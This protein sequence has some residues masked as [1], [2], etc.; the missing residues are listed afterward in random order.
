MPRID[1]RS[2]WW[3]KWVAAA[4]LLLWVLLRWADPDVADS[5]GFFLIFMPLWLLFMLRDEW[6]ILTGGVLVI[7]RGQSVQRVPLAAA[8]IKANGSVWQ[9]R[10]KEGRVTRKLTFQPTLAFGEAVVKAAEEG[11]AADQATVP[12]TEREAARAVLLVP[13]GVSPGQILLLVTA[14]FATFGLATWLDQPL[15]LLVWPVLVLVSD[16]LGQGGQI[17][18]AGEALYVL[19]AKGEVHEIPLSAVQSTRG[20]R[21]HELLITTRDPSYPVL[22]LHLAGQ[23]DFEKQ[24]KRRLSGEPPVSRRPEAGPADPGRP[25]GPMRCALCG[26]PEPGTV[27]GTG[28]FIC[29]RCGG[30]TRHEAGEAGHGLT[31][32][33]PKPM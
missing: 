12:L 11:R 1:R 17:L 15:I 2:R 10:W 18:L 30:R 7:R 25:E 33:E 19:G 4:F 32:K 16:R 5:A 22:Q 8:E 27:A 20:D 31:G 28:V 29:E 13:K 6:L 9:A 24:L 26:R 14:I 21:L 3:V 23:W